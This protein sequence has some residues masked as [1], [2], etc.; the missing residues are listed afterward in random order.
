MEVRHRLPGMT[1]DVRDQTPSLAQA[2]SLRDPGR[3]TEQFPQQRAMFRSDLRGR[4]RHV[5]LGDQEHVRGR[6]RIDVAKREH[7][8]GLVQAIA[9][10]GARRHATEQAFHSIRIASS[11]VREKA[12]ALPDAIPTH[13]GPKPA[14]ARQAAGA[15]IALGAI[16]AL[17]VCWIASGGASRLLLAVEI[18]DAAY[19]SMKSGRW[20]AL[21]GLDADLYHPGQGDSRVPVV[22]VP[23]AVEQG[24]DDPRVPP[25]ASL[26]AR[27]GFTVVVPNLPSLLALRVHPDNVRELAMFHR[28]VCERPDLAPLRRAGLFGVSYAGDVAL[29]VALDPR[30]AGAIP[31]VV[32]VGAYADLDT[33]LRFLATGRVFE[34]AWSRRVQV[35]P[36]GHLVFVRAYEEYMTSEPDRRT[37]EAIIARRGANPSAPI[38]D[39]VARL[40]PEGRLVID[41]FESHDEAL[42]PQLMARLPLGLKRRIALLSPARHDFS[43]LRARLYLAHARDD[44]IFPETESERLAALARPHTSVHRITLESLQH[45]EPQPWRKD[46]WGFLTSDLPEAGRLAGWWSALLAERGAPRQGRRPA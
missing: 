20:E 1:A 2:F 4:G 9:R 35:D 39:L 15:W 28:T 29:L 25:F 31:Y 37:L 44:G 27:A 19:R 8:I 21:G 36:Y 16:A 46:L 32:T 41:L 34:G 23:G 17:L 24:K 14:G 33:S 6:L 40:G 42:V 22:L 26:L 30:Y 11:E 10:R 13:P 18:L 43:A 7:A 5:L 12:L 45:V 38:G 3:E